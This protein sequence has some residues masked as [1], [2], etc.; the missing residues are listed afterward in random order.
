MAQ[1]LK[2]P[3]LYRLNRTCRDDGFR[4]GVSSNISTLLA[5]K[6][7]SLRYLLKSALCVVFIACLSAPAMGY[8]R[9]ELKTGATVLPA[10]HLV[11]RWSPGLI[12][13]YKLENQWFVYFDFTELLSNLP[14]NQVAGWERRRDVVYQ[15]DVAK[16]VKTFYIA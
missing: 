2:R 7:F 15:N 16:L 5:L 11:I 13:P 14:A 1:A 4:A 9:A 6:I 10:E 8:H 12:K 3:Q